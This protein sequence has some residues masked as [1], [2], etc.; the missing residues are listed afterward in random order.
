MAPRSFALL[1]IVVVGACI[2]ITY[3]V[4]TGHSSRLTSAE[5]QVAHNI[6]AHGRWFERNARADEYLTSLSK[7]EGGRLIDPASIDF[8]GLDR[9]GEWYPEVSL[10]VGASVVIAGLWALTGSERYIQIQIFQGI[11]DAL[12]ALLVYWIAMQLFKRPRAAMIAAALYALYPPLAWETIDPYNDIWA[13]DFTIV[14][15]ALYLVMSKSG[16]RW[17]WLIVCGLCAGIGAYFRPQVLLIA[18]ALA[19]ATVGVTGRREALRRAATT[20]VV[21]S[22]LL[23]PWTIRNY[24]DFHAFIPT[25]SAFWET[26]YAG[27]SELPSKYTPTSGE[28][29]SIPANFVP[30][31]GYETPAWEAHDKR[32]VI[33]LIEQH[34][35]F[36]LEVLAHRLALATVWL[37]DTAWMG[38]VAKTAFGY[39]GGLL[40][41]VVDRPLGA[42]EYVLPPLVFLL[43]MLSLWFTWRRWRRQ[44]LILLTT[45]LCVFLPYL[46]IHVDGRYLFPAIFAYFI[47]IGIG[48]D[49]LLEWV[50]RRRR[51]LA[52]AIHPPVRVGIPPET[53][54]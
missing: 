12:M 10:S 19:L 31:L 16:H 7:R 35:L 48:A 27:F 39:K 17:R 25:R 53:L 1:A 33:A 51:S 20:T 50:A 36:Y 38:R 44:N 24:E 45:V 13:V 28:P 18:P 41:F 6:V 5:G 8:S 46:A 47:W 2:R 30:H 22:L 9:N 43:G 49:Y 21:A 54:G 23:V 29:D 4:T 37:H 34:P 40:A 32:L 15:V 3:S 42:L 26:V 14:I 52:V 11:M